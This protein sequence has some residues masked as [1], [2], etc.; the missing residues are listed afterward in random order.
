MNGGSTSP[1]GRSYRLMITTFSCAY[2]AATGLY[3]GGQHHGDLSDP[4]RSVSWTRSCRRP[5]RMPYRPS[6]VP[7]RG[8]Y[9]NVPRTKA[10]I[11]FSPATIRRD[12]P[13]RQARYTAS[14]LAELSRASRRPAFIVRMS[15]SL[16]T[17]LGSMS[18]PVSASENRTVPRGFV[19]G[20]C[21]H[22]VGG[23]LSS[24]CGGW[25]GHGRWIRPRPFRFQSIFDRVG[26]A[27]TEEAVFR[28][29]QQ[30]CGQPVL[31]GEPAP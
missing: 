6:H 19:A 15:R 7:T 24:S 31:P 4:G 3:G 12:D 14:S 30:A 27:R 13:S 5:P 23:V 20:V 25:C 8:V 21:G 29:F 9:V 11:A 28:W 18:R 16:P 1:I 22:A 2:P 17:W 26:V 10:R